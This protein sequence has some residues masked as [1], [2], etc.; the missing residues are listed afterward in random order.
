[1]LLQRSFTDHCDLHTS[2]HITKLLKSS[3]VK[4][5]AKTSN[6]VL[7]L[8]SNIRSKRQVQDWW[9]QAGSNRRPPACKAGA[10][11]AEL[12]PLITLA[13]EPSKQKTAPLSSL[14]TS[15][16]H[17]N[18]AWWILVGLGGFEPPTSPLSGVRSNQLSYRPNLWV[19]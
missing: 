8:T 18:T 10:L 4:T 3:L 13:I 14:I 6:D 9:S 12:W 17:C 19:C 5:R 2:Y 11:P 15:F 16:Q 1:M 7:A